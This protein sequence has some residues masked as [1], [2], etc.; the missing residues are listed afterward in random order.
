M[1]VAFRSVRL[2]ALALFPLSA[3]GQVSDGADR[4]ETSGSLFTIPDQ[5]REQGDIFERLTAQQEADIIDRAF[6]LLSAKWPFNKVFVCWEASAAGHCRERDL[7][8][9]AIRETW[10]AESGLEFIGWG[11]C[12][13]NSRGIRIAVADAGPHV[14][15]L[16]KYVDGEP[17]GMVLNF[18]YANWS[19]SCRNR[20]DWCTR[21][22]AVHEFGHAIGFAHE[23]NRPDTPG[24]CRMDPQ[25]EDGDDILMTPWDPYSVMNY[26]NETY[27]NDGKLSEF[28][29]AAV[30]YI[31]GDPE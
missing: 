22:I 15:Y 9:D 30:R 27:A 14:K 28:D 23:Q 24:E 7:V 17:D 20:A 1:S 4:P 19:Q 13:E 25:G 16:G 12:G 21:T 2:L 29:I 3:S 5:P 26:C 10:E 6:P 18:T 31:Y 11:I 8:R